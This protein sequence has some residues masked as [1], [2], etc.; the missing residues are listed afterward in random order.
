M[1]VLGVW[2]PRRMCVFDVHDVETNAV[3]YDVRHPHKILYR[4]KQRK[5][6]KYIG[7]CLEGRCHFAPLLFS[8]DGVTVEVTKV[9]TNKLDYLLSKNG[10][11]NT[12]QHVV[13]SGEISS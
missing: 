10:T 5:K 2:D 4:H 6:G 7:T 13:V 8:V 1:G 9:T 11:D 3:S 12:Q